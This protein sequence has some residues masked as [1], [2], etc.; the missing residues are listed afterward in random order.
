MI[1]WPRSSSGGLPLRIGNSKHLFPRAQRYRRLA[2]PTSPQSRGVGENSSA[3]DDPMSSGSARIASRR[4]RLT[5]VCERG[6][7][8]IDGPVA[9]PFLLEFQAAWNRASVRAGERGG[10]RAGKPRCVRILTIT[11][12]SSMAAIIFSAPPPAGQCSMLQC[13][14][15]DCG[16]PALLRDF[17]R[18]PARSA[19]SGTLM[20]GQ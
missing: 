15:V 5:A 17:R 19:S 3:H 12:R 6:P 13:V 4:G 7:R 9:Q 11:A 20:R 2:G 16:R 10:A 14:D 1:V 8:R 18:R